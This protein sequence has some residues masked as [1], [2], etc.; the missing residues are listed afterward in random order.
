MYLNAGVD[1][2]RLRTQQLRDNVAGWRLNVNGIGAAAM[3][4]GRVAI[5]VLDIGQ[6]VFEF[7][8]LAQRF[9][10]DEHRCRVIGNRMLPQK[11][12]IVVAGC[13]WNVAETCK[14]FWRRIAILV[15]S[16]RK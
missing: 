5:D 11:G 2:M 6:L 3:M 13:G 12:T 15:G 7:V 8:A 16:G 1:R 10:V 9:V 14:L 4:F